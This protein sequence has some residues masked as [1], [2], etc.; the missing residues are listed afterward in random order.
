MQYNQPKLS[1]KTDLRKNSKKPKNMQ[2]Y[3]TIRIISE[4]LTTNEI[5]SKIRIFRAEYVNITI[6]IPY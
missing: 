1:K 6:P 3:K 4:N 2:K 5:H